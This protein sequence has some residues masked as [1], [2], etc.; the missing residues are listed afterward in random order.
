MATNQGYVAVSMENEQA[1][2]VKARHA[3]YM[4]SMTDASHRLSLPADLAAARRFDAVLYPNRSLSNT[5]F[6]LL[7]VGIAVVS[8]LVGLGFAL[9]GAWPVTG[10]LGL[11]VVLLYL[12][13]R[14]NF[15]QSSK[16]DTIRLDQCG[17]TVRRTLPHGK[18]QEWHFE[19][20][21]VQVV[22]E[23][24]QL[25]LRSHGNELTIGEFLTADERQTLARALKSAIQAH[26]AFR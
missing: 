13:F 6:L 17:L 15:Q 9:V 23:D 2:M 1:E 26:R 20:V 16:V 25:K 12:A 24:R 3:A 21:W 22:E 10:F 18:E 11:D 14:W 5:G 8:G 4:L 7:M 19:T